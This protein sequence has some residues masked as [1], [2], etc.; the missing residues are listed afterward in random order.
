[1]P[2]TCGARPRLPE[3]IGAMESDHPVIIVG[4]VFVAG[5]SVFIA[6]VAWRTIRKNPNLLSSWK[7]PETAS[8]WAWSV[9]LGLFALIGA[10]F[11]IWLATKRHA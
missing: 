9:F 10:A 11:R 5:L 2:S 1:V 6:A 4:S 3:N 7:A 8:D